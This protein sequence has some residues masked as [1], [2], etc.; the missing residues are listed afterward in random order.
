MP[1]SRRIKRIE[2]ALDEMLSEGYTTMD[3]VEIAPD[4]GWLEYKKE[5]PGAEAEAI[6]ENAVYGAI[7]GYA[8]D[9]QFSVREVKGEKVVWVEDNILANKP[10]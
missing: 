3:G 7:E 8:G 1:N 4:R 9:T 10:K 5:L 6:P 2:L